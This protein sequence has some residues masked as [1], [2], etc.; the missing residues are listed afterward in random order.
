M[1]FCILGLL[2]LGPA[3]LYELNA[4]FARS[5][6]L[7]YRASLGSLQAAL[8]KLL[9]AG[10]VEIASEEPGGRRKRLYRIR[11][12]GR[13]RFFA[14]MSAPLPETRLEET[15][16][17]RYHFLGFLPG[18][19]ERATVLDRIISDA[20]KALAGLETLA[21]EISALVIPPEYLEMFRYQRGTLEY[22]IAA[23]RSALRWFR[24]RRAE[25]R[26]AGRSGV[27]SRRM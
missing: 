6:S 11:E 23:H 9:A 20:G 12:E 22:G 16:L 18:P 25:E 24:R 13:A 27:V 2:M 21:A 14:L 8:R 7:F 1:D 17:A 4:A 19:A 5:L 15:A 10:Y 26:R 3:S